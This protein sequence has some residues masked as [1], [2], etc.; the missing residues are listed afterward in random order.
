MSFS[1]A[2]YSPEKALVAS[3]TH[4]AKMLS[5]GILVCNHKIYHIA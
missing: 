2:A 1:G 3:A 5:R 4:D